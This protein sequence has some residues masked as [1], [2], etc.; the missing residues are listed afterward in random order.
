MT[1]MALMAGP[2]RSDASISSANVVVAVVV[3][4]EDAGVGV[5]T[6]A[7]DGL[8]VGGKVVDCG[9]VGGMGVGIAVVSGS[10][11]GGAG[12]GCIV[13]GVGVVGVGGSADSGGV[14][15]PGVAAIGVGA[16][17]VGEDGVFSFSSAPSPSPSPSP[18]LSCNMRAIS[19]E[20]RRIAF[21]I[22]PSLLPTVEFSSS[23]NC[24]SHSN[25]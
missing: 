21:C 17:G 10:S 24:H 20:P 11:D 7:V 18:P 8:G 15:G 23:T 22:P 14:G 25:S 12:V 13:S 9:G 3:A 4:G 19:L 5:G 6:W 2:L 16:A 1:N